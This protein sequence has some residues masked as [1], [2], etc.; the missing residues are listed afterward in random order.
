MTGIEEVDAFDGLGPVVHRHAVDHRKRWVNA[1][2]ALL[3]AVPSGRLGVWVPWYGRAGGPLLAGAA[4]CVA[5]VA[6][7]ILFIVDHPDKEYRVSAGEGMTMV[8][9]I[10]PGISSAG[11]D[12]L[13]AGMLVCAVT[14]IPLVVLYVQGRA[15]R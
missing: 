12:F 10:E 2:C 8:Q 1:G 15:Y 3:V 13:A 5:A 4:A 7:M 14:A 9:C 11:Y 6:A